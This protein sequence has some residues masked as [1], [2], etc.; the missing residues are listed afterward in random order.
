MKIYAS[1]SLQKGDNKPSDTHTLFWLRHTQDTRAAGGTN[2]TSKWLL[3]T[4]NYISH[5]GNTAS[6]EAQNIGV[7]IPYPEGDAS[8]QHL[9][10]H[11][12]RNRSKEICDSI[13][14]VTGYGAMPRR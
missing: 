9:L 1:R 14:L 4:L 11:L 10:Q 3:L 7:K 8:H 2:Q 12:L 13:R 5:H 6:I